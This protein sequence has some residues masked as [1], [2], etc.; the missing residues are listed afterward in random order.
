MKMK[1]QM[2]YANAKHIPFVALA[3]ESEMA[4]GKITLKNMVTGEQ[5]LLTPEDII[6]FIK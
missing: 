4:A 2:S 6:T 3:G 1:K 5:Q